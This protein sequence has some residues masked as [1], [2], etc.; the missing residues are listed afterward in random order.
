[1]RERPKKIAVPE[2]FDDRG[3]LWPIELEGEARRFYIVK[4]W[5]RLGQHVRAWHGHPNEWRLVKCLSGS[6][7]ISCLNLDDHSDVESFFLSNHPEV[8]FMPAGWAMGWMNIKPGTKLLFA[9]PT[10]YADRDDVRLDPSIRDDVWVKSDKCHD[11]A[12]ESRKET[13]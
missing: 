5:E 12:E 1:M 9:A 2:K 6:A 8:V 11:A 7:Q 10:H 3:R 4:N 13:K